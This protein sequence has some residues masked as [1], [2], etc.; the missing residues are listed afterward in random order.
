[1]KRISFDSLSLAAIVAELQP[2]V[3]GKVQR[4]WQPDEHTA[5]LDLYRQGEGFFMLCAQPVYAR[6]HF[7]TRKPRNVQPMPGLGQALCA[8]LENARLVA[9]KQVG[10]DRILHLDFEAEQGPHRLIAELMGKHSNIMLLDKEARVIAAAKSVGRTKSVRPIFPGRRYEPPPF[11]PKP[12]ILD[13]K[14]GEELKGLQGASPFLISL[15]GALGFGEVRHAVE[16]GSF[17]P[18]LVPGVG[19][20]SVSV[21]PL[22]LEELPRATLSIA[23]EQHYETAITEDQAATL[24]ESLLGQLR[25]VLLAREVALADLQEAA[26]T[27]ARAGSLQLMGEL[28]LAYGSTLPDGSRILE[29]EDYAG[30]P[31]TVKLDPEKTS[32]ENAQA[33]FDKAKRAKGR[34]GLVKDQIGRIGADKEALEGLMYRVENSSLLKELEDLREEA[35][36]RRW[37]HEQRTPEEA[38]NKEERPYQGHR[39]RELMGPGG[40]T[41]LYGENAESNDYLT[42]RVAKPNDWW[43]H[44]R[45]HISAHVVILTGNQP[46]KVSREALLFAAKVAVQNSPLKHSGYV[47]V[48]YTLKKYVRKPK[49]GPKG[50]ALYTHEKTLHIES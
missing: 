22:G 9:A 23:L 34:E 42:L 24:R 16:S 44:V 48:D 46:D 2:F 12:S 5:V 30:K 17:Q 29:A 43:L 28:I 6:A 49:G 20:Y 47:P 10:F 39:I 33:Y 27:A 3:G 32:L 13:A 19:A 36:K 7:I 14:P 38:K 35:R 26:D 31:L 25:R 50:T 45:G 11:D 40:L 41:V 18:V 8:R 4:S 21:A 15:V 37:L 1:L